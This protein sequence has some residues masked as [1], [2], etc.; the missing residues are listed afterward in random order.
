MLLAVAP[1][2]DE[3]AIRAAMRRAVEAIEYEG[4]P[5]YGED[6][7]WLALVEQDTSGDRRVVAE[8]FGGTWS[9]PLIAAGLASTPVPRRNERPA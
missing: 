4:R 6:D 9:N 1:A 5:G 7:V 2:H 3:T 8:L